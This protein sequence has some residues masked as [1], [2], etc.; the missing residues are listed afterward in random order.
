MTVYLKK[1]KGTEVEAQKLFDTANVRLI[2]ES[3]SIGDGIGEWEIVIRCNDDF[4]REIKFKRT[5]K[6]LLSA[7]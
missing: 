3:K 4:E 1:I 7:Y 6:G 2:K 5:I